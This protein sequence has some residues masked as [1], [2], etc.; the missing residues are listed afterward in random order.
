MISDLHHQGAER[1]VCCLFHLS[2]EM[3]SPEGLIQKS[4][5]L[6][7][8]GVTQLRGIGS[9]HCKSHWGNWVR[10]QLCY[11][12]DQRRRSSD[13]FLEQ[14]TKRSRAELVIF[15]MLHNNIWANI[16]L[17]EHFYKTW[18]H[19]KKQTKTP[20]FLSCIFTV[21]WDLFEKLGHD[22]VTDLTLSC[23]QWFF[24]FW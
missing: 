19:I 15:P 24:V 22:S 6:S 18:R 5:L 11:Y 17:P 12:F 7:K 21:V 13:S 3:C 4:V 23:W 1:S 14:N 20:T 10:F 2:L 8:S 9:A 16:L